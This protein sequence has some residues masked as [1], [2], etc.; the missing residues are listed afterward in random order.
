MLVSGPVRWVV[1]RRWA[2][3]GGEDNDNDCETPEICWF[4]FTANTEGKEVTDTR[5]LVSVSIPLDEKNDTLK[6]LVFVLVK[7]F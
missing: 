4:T 3:S 1:S 2:F 6:K 7:R 5:F